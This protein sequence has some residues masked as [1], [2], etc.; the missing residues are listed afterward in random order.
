MVITTTSFR[1]FENIF[2]DTVGPFPTSHKENMFRSLQDDL[3][4][5]A[6][7]VPMVNHVANTVAVLR[8]IRNS[9]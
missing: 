7:A 4:K 5:L 2:M 1:P 6:W 3:S 9:I 8:T